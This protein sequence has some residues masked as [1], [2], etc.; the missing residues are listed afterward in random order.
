MYGAWPF[1]LPGYEETTAQ[2]DSLYYDPK[3]GKKVPHR[4][5]HP[6]IRQEFFPEVIK[7]ANARGIKVHAYIGKNTYNGTYIQKHCES[8]AQSPVA[9]ALPFTLGLEDYWRAFIKRILEIG[10]N[11]FVFED[12]E[13]YHVPNQNEECYRTFWAPWGSDDPVSAT[14]RDWCS[15]RFGARLF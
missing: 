13:A 9:E 14:D 3:T 4:Y 12:P 6:N 10:F 1:T 7:Y 2:Y 15:Q 11:G 5:V 8:N